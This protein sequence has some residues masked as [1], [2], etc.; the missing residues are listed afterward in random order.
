MTRIYEAN[1]TQPAVKGLVH[2]ARSIY[3]DAWAEP[4]N[5][6]TY[7]IVV[8]LGAKETGVRAASV[9]PTGVDASRA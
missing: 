6:G 4:N 5:D 2:D 8:A 3:N 1:V 7:T 9:Q